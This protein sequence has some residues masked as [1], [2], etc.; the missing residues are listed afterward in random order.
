MDAQNATQKDI[1]KNKTYHVSKWKDQM[2]KESHN[3]LPG[4]SYHDATVTTLDN[5]FCKAF[6]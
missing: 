5:A 3:V 1:A 4:I 2:V 6:N